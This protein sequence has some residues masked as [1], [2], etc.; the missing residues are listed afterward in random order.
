M[1]VRGIYSLLLV[2]SILF[3]SIPLHASERMPDGMYQADSLMHCRD[4]QKALPVLEKALEEARAREDSGSMAL[5]YC[6]IGECL[7]MTGKDME[8]KEPLKRAIL[9]AEAMKNQALMGR[10]LNGLGIAHEYTGSY[11]SAFM[12]YVKALHI[13]EMEKDTSGIATSV[14]NM[15]QILRVM[16]RLE[17]ARKYC[18]KAYELIPGLNDYT[19]EANI[20]N[21]TA[22]LFELEGALDSAR[23]Y[24]EKLI[25]LS[26]ANQYN[27]GIAVGLS[28]LAAVHEREGDYRSSLALKKEGL[29]LD[30][31][32]GNNHGM[33]V[34]CCLI[35]EN[36]LAMEDFRAALAYLDSASIL[37]DSSWLAKL[38]QIQGLRSDVYKASGDYRNAL[39][40]YEMKIRYRDSLFSVQNHRN[41]EDIRV[42]Y[43]TGQKEQAILLLDRENKIKTIQ[44]HLAW[45]LVLS[46]FL[47]S[48]AGAVISMQLLRSR[49]NRIEQMK[50]EIRNHILQLQRLEGEE[51][52]IRLSKLA[53][54]Y[55]IT[56]RERDVLDLLSRGMAND[57][58]ASRLYI[59]RNTVKFHIKNIF[60]K[61]DVRNRMEA[62]QKI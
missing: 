12:N 30:R 58:I 18:R 33:V 26:R 2:F 44:L 56:A 22:Y 46:L 55:K 13:R 19:I 37:C 4:F 3:P 6:Q 36:C 25:E 15:A 38:E 10:A 23:F 17:E 61:L 35:A 21:E 47:L 31:A 34:S 24:Y 48:G 62:M 53:E 45:I 42:R 57:E 16:G 50:L 59:S 9:G 5:L 1:G 43:E 11:D 14:R 7:Y 8:S 40:H 29:E 41:I 39:L 32:S 20:Y 54:K 51:P 52:E 49:K 60:M 27:R 28:N